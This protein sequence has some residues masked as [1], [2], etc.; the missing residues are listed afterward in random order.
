MWEIEIGPDRA[1]ELGTDRVWRYCEI[2][3]VLYSESL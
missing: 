3:S 2:R 1:L